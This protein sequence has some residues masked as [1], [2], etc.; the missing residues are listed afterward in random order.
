MDDY[1]EIA[2]TPDENYAMPCGVLIKSILYTNPNK[3]IRFH[4]ISE[5]ISAESKKMLMKCIENSKSNIIFYA[6]D[7]NLLCGLPTYNN[8]VATYII[9]FI[10]TI[11][12]N[13]IEKIIYFDAD[14]IVV[15]NL[16]KL[17]NID[18]I[19]FPMAG[20]M[21]IT[22]DDIRHYNRLNYDCSKGYYSCGT[23]ILN[24]KY[25]R[26]NDLLE[27]CLYVIKNTPQGILIF[28]DQDVL[29]IVLMDKW[30]KL[31]PQYNCFQ[32]YYFP[33]YSLYIKKEYHD[34]I[35]YAR[36]NPIIIHFI[37]NPKPWHKDY[38]MPLK[39]IW[40]FFK[41]MSPW[42]KNKLKYYYN[43]LRLQK[44]RIRRVL[45]TLHILK[46]LIWESDPKLNMVA[47]TKDI[48]SQIEKCNHELL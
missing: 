30:K 32:N 46:P 15:G 47:I 12:P 8:S 20:A 33:I 36:L 40:L 17:W 37:S 28:H 21:S 10:A 23:H 26:Q 3:K 39:K 42:R 16:D 27:K 25:W 1:I 19:D 43:G 31:S 18:I 5:N 45:E 41:E 22:N 2:I 14:M 11:L 7:N 9:L 44:Y 13:D 34:E 29:N 35:E 38:N 6:I 48:F 4:I 24:L